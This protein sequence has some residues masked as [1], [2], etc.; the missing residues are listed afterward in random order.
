VSG[1]INNSCLVSMGALYNT[2]FDLV[3]DD[4]V[5]A[6]V[7]A[8]NAR[9]FSEYSVESASES[10]QS[11]VM[12]FLPVMQPPS[13]LSKSEVQMTLE[14]DNLDDNYSYELWKEGAS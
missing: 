4:L 8:E 6:R 2:P 12:E 10:A 7:R 1:E 13:I 3:G 5:V 9:G 14:W 11:A